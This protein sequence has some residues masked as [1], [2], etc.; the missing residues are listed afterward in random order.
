[1]TKPGDVHGQFP[2][3][4]RISKYSGMGTESNR[5]RKWKHIK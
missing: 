1:M 2:E 3:A 5:D 4:Y